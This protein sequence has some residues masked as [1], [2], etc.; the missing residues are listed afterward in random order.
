M[1]AL[2]AEDKV[3]L[4]G[5]GNDEV[6][7]HLFS[8]HGGREREGMESGVG[9]LRLQRAKGGRVSSQLASFQAAPLKM[10]T[11][12][13]QLSW[14]FTSR[15]TWLCVQCQKRQTLHLLVADT[16]SKLLTPNTLSEGGAVTAAENY[17]FSPP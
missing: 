4:F 1:L 13:G 14:T 12:R 6:E 16:R 11:D 2:L 3:T 10:V 17:D 7:L 5:F 15:Q 9:H 8:Q